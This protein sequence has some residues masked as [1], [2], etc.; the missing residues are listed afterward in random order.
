MGYVNY[1]AGTLSE[2]G[3][4]QICLCGAKSLD[5]HAG[6]AGQRIPDQRQEWP[7]SGVALFA[8]NAGLAGGVAAETVA[9]V[10]RSPTTKSCRI[11]IASAIERIMGGLVFENLQFDGVPERRDISEGFKQL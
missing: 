3:H 4:S 7:G 5:A 1:H 11:R 9:T 8:K 10:G 6:P 2:Y